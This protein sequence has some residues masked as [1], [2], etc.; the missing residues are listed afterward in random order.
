M[1]CDTTRTGLPGTR[2]PDS[3]ICFQYDADL[4]ENIHLFV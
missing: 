4:I 3:E 2:Y 1:D